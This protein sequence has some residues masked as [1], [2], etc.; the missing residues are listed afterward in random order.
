MFIIKLLY[1][2]YY[3]NNLRIIDEKSFRVFDEKLLLN[4]LIQETS[5][6]Q[7]HSFKS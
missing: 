6:N 4:K 7:N 5:D 3:K 1:N 2:K